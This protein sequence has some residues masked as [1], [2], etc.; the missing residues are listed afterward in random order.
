MKMI[1]KVCFMLVVCLFVV[2]CSDN[3]ESNLVDVQSI[4]TSEVKDIIDNNNEDYIIIDVREDYEYKEGHL[5]NAVNIPL[6][7]INTVSYE[8]NKIIIVYC[9]SGVRSRE[10]ANKLKNM[11]Y[12]VKD[13]GG[14]IDW[15][16]ELEGE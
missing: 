7:N 3:T 14:I 8:K 13:M 9:R 15:N 6:G 11:G 4:T 10:A 2:G 5:K 12:T 1:F 16:Y